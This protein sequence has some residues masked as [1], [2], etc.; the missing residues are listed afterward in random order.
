MLIWVGTV[1]RV[2]TAIWLGMA[3]LWIFKYFLLGM[4]IW[5]GTLTDFLKNVNR[6]AYSGRYVN[7]GL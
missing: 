5:I 6:Y 3:I 4:L 2:G 7:S 1:I